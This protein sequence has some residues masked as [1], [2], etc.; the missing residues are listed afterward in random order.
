VLR[1][2]C[3]HIHAQALPAPPPFSEWRLVAARVSAFSSRDRRPY[4]FACANTPRAS[5]TASRRF[6][7]DGAQL[8]KVSGSVTTTCEKA[9]SGN[10]SSARLGLGACIVESIPKMI[11][12]NKNHLLSCSVERLAAA[13]PQPHLL[14]SSPRRPRF[15]KLVGKVPIEM[16]TGRSFGKK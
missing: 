10:R 9:F 15:E 7:A 4:V 13:R 12:C 5:F 2:W 14:A 6:V 1:S 16:C 11:C 8:A 3:I